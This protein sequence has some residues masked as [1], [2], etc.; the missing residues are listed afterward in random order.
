MSVDPAHSVPFAQSQVDTDVLPPTQE[1]EGAVGKTSHG[2]GIRS[3]LGALRQWFLAFRRTRPFWGGLWMILGGWAILRF[4]M[5]P[6]R[7]L[8]RFGFSGFAGYFLGG[9]LIAFGLVCWFLPSNRRIVGVLAVC[10]AIVSLVESNLGGF[11]VGMFFGV[12]GGCMAFGWG[13]KKPT[14]RMLRRQAAAE[15]AG[16]G[17]P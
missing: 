6:L 15:P 5:I 13:E 8:T 2:K 16:A 17:R 11:F 9:G 7:L 10:F 12:L 1:H 3:R 4:A 14:R